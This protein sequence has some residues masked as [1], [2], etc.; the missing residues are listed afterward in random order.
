MRRAAGLH[1]GLTVAMFVCVQAAAY[2]S[3]ALDLSPG[4]V[5]SEAITCF[6]ILGPAVGLLLSRARVAAALMAI[7]AVLLALFL[8]GLGVELWS[9]ASRY[10]ALIM[11]VYVL[12]PLA[13]AGSWLAATWV[14]C[15]AFLASGVLK[16]LAAS[17]AL[18]A[19]STFD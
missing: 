5:A 4:D 14:A 15:R 1:I 13:F 16:R 19:A 11:Y 12:V 17:V 10:N 8:G 7:V 9:L 6:V 2:M 3:N 18:T